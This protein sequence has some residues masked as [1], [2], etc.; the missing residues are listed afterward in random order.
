MALAQAGEAAA[1]PWVAPGGDEE[2]PPVNYRRFLAAV[3]RHKW[4]VLVLGALG[5]AG[6]VV[7]ARLVPKEYPAQA[8]LWIGVGD[9]GDRGPIRSEQLLDQ[10]SWSDLL[11]SFV[12][13]DEVVRRERLYLT[14]GDARD[15][16][17][18]RGFLLK[19]RFFPGQY[20]LRVDESGHDW[21]LSRAGIVVQRGAVGDSV[22]LQSG[23]E[24]APPA[25]ELRASRIIP[26]AIRTPRD[27]ALQISDN[28]NGRLPEQG[29]FLRLSLVGDDPV[30]V[31]GTLNGIADRFVEVAANLKR[32]KLSELTRIL[33]EQLTS[34]YAD[35]QRAEAALEGFRVQTITLP[36]DQSAPVAAG[37]QETRDPVF[38]QFFQLRIG[39]ETLER[40]R[41]AIERVL[42][43]QGDSGLS[44]VQLETIPSVRESSDLTRAL[45]D[46]TNKEAEARATRLQYT[47]GY[48]PLQRL[49]SEIVQLRRHVVPVMARQ[50]VAELRTRQAQIDAQLAASSRELQQIPPRVIEEARLKRDVAIAENLYTTLQQRFEE[51]R[52]AEV[53]SIPDVRILDR[54]VAPDQPLKNRAIMLVVGGLAGGLGAALALAI[55]LD[56]MDRRLR[57]PEQVSWEMGLP[58]LGTVPRLRR[59]QVA[60]KG[61]D[62]AMVVEALRT[63]RLN[64]VHAYGAAGPLI[65]VITSPGPGD[66]KSFLASNLSL[67]FA[68]AGHRT[69]LIDGDIRRGA[70]HRLLAAQRKPGLLDYLGGQAT[71]DQIIQTPSVGGVDFIGCG[72]RRLAGPELLASP[73]MSQLLIGLRSNYSVILIDCSP[74]GAAVDPLI[75]GALTGSLVMVMRTGVTDRQLAAAKLE[76][77]ARLPIR[78]LGVVLNDV[79]QDA[80]YRTYYYSYGYLPGYE[81]S[82]EGEADRRL[83]EAKPVVS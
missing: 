38:T 63:I 7:G 60:G 65:T 49:D 66:G 13:L 52:L 80:G 35:L 22:G 40:D 33:R 62:S 17:A 10:S 2:E 74:L 4:L 29:S 8:T 79:R 47:D 12:V 82:E 34:S 76:A 64:L 43:T 26:F 37:L 15:A 16:S 5:L 77:V 44:A 21:T 1:A 18:L 69:L 75:L 25:A 81:T 68:D 67:S 6:G 19:Q 83:G 42:A 71:R 27:A 9:R 54:A 57:Y 28:L 24:W 30:R 48:A 56:R 46:L 59:S 36:Q 50:V 78:V 61:E 14:L 31:A 58:I 32:D 53:S 41:A 45:A 20:Q 72:T 55:L 23:F 70:L 3:L 51:A 39:R 11:R 73:A